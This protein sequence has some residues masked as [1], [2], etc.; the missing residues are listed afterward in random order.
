MPELCGAVG[1]WREGN[2]L[3][4]RAQAA[5]KG[6]WNSPCP[7]SRLGTAC[8]GQQV[9]PS[10]FC[11]L[12]QAGQDMGQVTVLAVSLCCSGGPGSVCWC[13]G[14]ACCAAG[15]A[16][17]CVVLCSGLI[18]LQRSCT[19]GCSSSGATRCC[20]W[21]WEMTSMTWGK[22]PE[23]GWWGVPGVPCSSVLGLMA[24]LCAAP[25]MGLLLQLSGNVLI[26]L[27][28][29]LCQDLGCLLLQGVP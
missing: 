16:L 5:L 20:P 23:Q 2:V 26:L 7:I 21:P 6:T 3:W 22:S 12:A 24:G 29:L 1:G 17:P 25:T 27:I 4:P 10:W 14:S 9:A 13:C 18:S 15:A 8:E 28:T 11:E 19:N